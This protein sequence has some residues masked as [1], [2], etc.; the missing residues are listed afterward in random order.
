MSALSFI[1]EY[2]SIF[3]MHIM[4]EYTTFSFYGT[5]RKYILQT[6]FLKNDI[7]TLNALSAAKDWNPWE[8][9]LNNAVVSTVSNQ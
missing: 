2:S 8:L 3:T 9:C 6:F 4:C 1:N 5:D 7:S